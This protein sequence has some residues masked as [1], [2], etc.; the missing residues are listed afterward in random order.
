MV[1]IQFTDSKSLIEFIDGLQKRI[2]V[3]PTTGV[4]TQ[5]A[6]TQTTNQI[7]VA[8]PEGIKV[9][10]DSKAVSVSQGWSYVENTL[11]K[12]ANNEKWLINWENK[13][14]CKPN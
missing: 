8:S 4:T 1:S 11:T 12:T 7:I 2:E 14:I 13:S 6:S 10:W 3:Q 5:V 9:D